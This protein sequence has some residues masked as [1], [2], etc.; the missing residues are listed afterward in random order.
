MADEFVEALKAAFGEDVAFGAGIPSRFGT[1]WSGLEPV[2]PLALV[3]PCTTDEVATALKLCNRFAVPVVPQGGLTGLAGGARP[4][5][6]GI[7]LSLDPMNGVEGN[8]PVM[9]TMNV[10]ARKLLSTNQAPAH[11][12]RVV[13]WAGPSARGSCAI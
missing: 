9:A 3:R 12:A 8:E 5:G 10:P 1:D 13:F 7:A 6:G 4:I 11:Q 2:R